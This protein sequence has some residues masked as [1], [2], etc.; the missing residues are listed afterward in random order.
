MKLFR[1]AIAGAVLMASLCAAQQVNPAL[2][3]RS[4]EADIRG[5]YWMPTAVADDYFDGTSSR[6][7]VRRHMQVAQQVGAKYLRCSFTWNAIENQRGKYNWKFWDML[8]DEAER[9]NIKLIPYVAYTPEWAAGTP[10]QFWKRP[11][12]DPKFYADTMYQVARR[13]RGRI[14]SWEI[15]NE[16]DIE[17]YWMGS[18]ERFAELVRLAAAAIRKADPNATLVLAGMSKGPSPFFRELIEKYDVE[19]LVDVIAM[20]G[21]PESWLEER[22]ETVH[23]SW[24]DKMADLLEADGARQDLWLNEIGYAD[25]RFSPTLANKYGVT[26]P[27]PHEHTPQY[28]ATALFK[29]QVMALASGKVT[30]TGWYR[31]DDFD[32]KTTT[33]SDDHVN[34]HLGLLDYRGKRKPTFYALRYFN[35]LFDKPSRALA[36]R[37]LSSA[38]MESNAVVNV[39]ERA[40]DRV[41]VV[42]WLRSLNRDETDADG[43]EIDARHETAAVQLPCSRISDMRVT[44]AQGNAAAAFTTFQNG[45]LD[46]LEL[47]PDRIFIASMQCDADTTAFAVVPGITK[48]IVGANPSRSGVNS[49]SDRE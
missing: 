35:K 31:I 38:A 15:W 2:N 42:A 47:R 18:T 11:P 14:H 33:F 7:R 30:L 16:P 45:W 41:V 8:V 5:F 40:D 6:E 43:T 9:T 20:H 21:Y 3:S 19:K 28:A 23:Q 44:D 24:V 26:A 4:R 22:A 48:N 39:I 1:L 10:D 34:F 36:A 17:E 37:T 29:A 25:Y 46:G 32:P 12:T 27:F 49:S 13:Y